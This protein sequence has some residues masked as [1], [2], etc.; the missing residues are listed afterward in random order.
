MAAPRNRNAGFS[1]RAQAGVFFGYVIAVAGVGVAAVVLAIQTLDPNAFGALRGGVAELTTPL[2]S[3]MAWV[4]RSIGSIPGGIGEHFAVVGQNQAL[5]KKL[6]GVNEVFARAQS[7]ERE[8]KRLRALLG[9]RDI[10]PATIVT[11]RLVS[12]SASSTRRF[13]TLNAGFRQGVA[14]GQP[15]RGPEGL[16]GRVLEAGPDSARILLLSDP[17]SI[18]PVRRS[19]DGLPAIATGRG[20][21]LIDIKPIALSN[22]ALHRGDLLTSSGVGG[23]FPPDIPVA[24]II[25]KTRDGLVARGIARA[26][27]LDI[28]TVMRPFLQPASQPPTAP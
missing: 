2:S 16:I 22:T 26:D 15:V 3:G 6:R 19:S 7:L 1:R 18:V 5:R 23:L 14:V 11:A 25:G 24:R 4:T 13:A 27:T 8:N 21:G 12:S 10:S 17:E 28:A 9:V 20:D